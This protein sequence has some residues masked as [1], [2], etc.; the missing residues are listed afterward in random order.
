MVN[1]IDSK[2]PDSPKSDCKDTNHSQFLDYVIGLAARSTYQGAKAAVKSIPP[3]A[4]PKAAEAV[5]YP[6]AAEA[7]IKKVGGPDITQT[8]REHRKENPKTAFVEGLASPHLVTADAMF[9]KYFGK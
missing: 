9:R 4:I 2:T 8:R 1:E 5:V 3:D 6:L 7:A